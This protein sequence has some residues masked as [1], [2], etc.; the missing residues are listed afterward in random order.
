[1]F[2][3]EQCKTILSKSLNGSYFYWIPVF[4]GMGIFA[5][6]SIDL[7]FNLW[8][9]AISTLFCLSGGYYLLKAERPV[10]AVLIFVFGFV[11]LGLCLIQ[12]R[13]QQL[14]TVFIEK[15]GLYQ[16][17]G[18][19]KTLEPLEKNIRVIL[20]DVALEKQGAFPSDIRLQSYHAKDLKIGERVSALTKLR[21][22]SPPVYPDGFDFRRYAYFRGWGAVGFTLSAFTL[23]EPSKD[24][25]VAGF[26]AGLRRSIAA[27]LDKV[28]NPQ[29]A[30]VA[31]ALLIGERTAISKDVLEQVRDAGLAHLLAIS[32]LHV[33]LM[34]GFIFFLVRGL[35][36]AIPYIALRVPI[37]KVAAVFALMAAIFYMLLVGAPIPTQRAVVMT[38][39]IFIAILFDRTA[40]SFRTAAFA[41]LIIMV[42]RPEAITEVS[43]Q[44]SFSAVLSLIA[45]YEWAYKKLPK[46]FY[47]RSFFNRFGIYFLGVGVTSLIASLATM[48]FTFYHFQSFPLLGILSNLAAIPLVSFIIMPLGVLS[49]L[50]MP[51]NLAE[52]FMAV[53]GWGIE[54]VISIAEYTASFDVAVLHLPQIPTIAV[55]LFVVGALILMLT[56]Q[57]LRVYGFIPLI[58]GLGLFP[59]GNVPDIV[60]SE[61]AGLIGVKTEQGLRVNTL[62]RDKFVSESWAEYFGQEFDDVTLLENCD[63][64]A[65][66]VSLK[67]KNI[68]Y[69]YNQEALS[70]ACKSS[71]IIVASFFIDNKEQCNAPMIIDRIDV[72]KNGAYALWLDRED[73]IIKTV[74]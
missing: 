2:L 4:I 57:P 9:T 70:E 32:G 37:K 66:H 1:M 36:A 60:I 55:V 16:V 68:S 39:L 72:W 23:I 73:V 5:Y 14:Q 42:L 8:I 25:S 62:R 43:F 27:Q 20:T 10:I 33:G 64:S 19:V 40:I 3:I 18:T 34:A 44:L 63:K 28:E 49:V 45:F 26:F 50:A 13:A 48:P 51:F 29:A 22:P 61:N 71:D 35:L 56:K 53:M 54:G 15:E 38:G 69:V 47:S 11:L 41:A 12:F 59:F 7:T 46:D 24:K 74:K 6:F 30:A 65:C 17:E 52:P 21:P 58:I 31:K 67:G